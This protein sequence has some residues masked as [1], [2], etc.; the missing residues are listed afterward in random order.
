MESAGR[1]QPSFFRSSRRSPSQGYLPSIAAT[2]R[3]RTYWSSVDDG[4]R[5]GERTLIPSAVCF[6]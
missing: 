2:L 4:G 6:A 1:A 3:N 5:G